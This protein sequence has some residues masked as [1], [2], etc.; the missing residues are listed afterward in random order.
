MSGEEKDLKQETAAATKAAKAAVAEPKAF[1]IIPSAKFVTVGGNKIRVPN[2]V[3][4][5]KESDLTPELVVK[6]PTKRQIGGKPLSCY[7]TVDGQK[8][9]FDAKGN[10]V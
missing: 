2:T 10:L 6:G 1:T 8:P 7:V 3:T 4:V 5:A 9:M